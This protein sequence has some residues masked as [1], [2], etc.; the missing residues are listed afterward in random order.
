[1]QQHEM[2]QWMRQALRLAAEGLAKDELP[3]G[4]VVV[5]D[6]RVIA[7]AHTTERSAGRLLVHAELLALEDADRLRPFPGQ[8]RDARLFTTLEPCLMCLGAAMSFF[9]GEVYYGVESPGDGAMSLIRQ[10]QRNEQDFPA[11]R[12]PHVAGGVLRD[13]AI[14][15]FRAY[16][17][18][19]TGGAMW[20]WARTIAV[21]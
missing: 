12:L 16:V 9:V 10:W 19:H 1:V 7:A 4:A 21:L 11:Y 15:L 13:E 6:S 14:A 20:E 18:R 8:R 17:A 5:L 3:I 2:E